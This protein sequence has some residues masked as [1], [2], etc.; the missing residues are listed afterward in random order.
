MTP[1]NVDRN[2]VEEGESER[3]ELQNMWLGKT[4]EGIF[5]LGDDLLV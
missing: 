4:R 3:H 2:N 5:V 1:R